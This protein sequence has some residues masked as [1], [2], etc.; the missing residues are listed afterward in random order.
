MVFYAEEDVFCQLLSCDLDA[1]FY[2]L[3]RVFGHG[4]TKAFWTRIRTEDLDVRELVC[5]SGL[6]KR[7]AW[8]CHVFPKCHFVEEHLEVPIRGDIH[9]AER[10]ARHREYLNIIASFSVDCS[11]KTA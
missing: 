3:V 8:W 10:S 5:A 4:A 2:Q 9:V 6:G 11:R 1:S 7:L